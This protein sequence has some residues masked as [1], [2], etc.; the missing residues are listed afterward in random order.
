MARAAADRIDIPPATEVQSRP[1]RGVQ[2]MVEGRALALGSTRLL[3][4]AGIT[5]EPAL[6]TSAKT[7]EADGRTISWLIDRGTRN[8]LGLIA[9]GD[10]IKPT[11]AAAIA[12]LHAQNI[13]VALLTG[14]NQ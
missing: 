1:G 11:A 14:D 2:A 9:F 5:P 8:T 6:A 4:E 10:A 13:R 7:L 12:A 3:D